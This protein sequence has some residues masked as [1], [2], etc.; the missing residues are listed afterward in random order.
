MTRQV[1]RNLLKTGLI[2]AIAAAAAAPD[3]RGQ[4]PV[5]AQRQPNFIVIY[6]DDLGYADIGPFSTAAK[7]RRPRTPHLDR[8]AAQGARL[9]SF[10]VAQAVCSASRAALLTGSY[11]N[12][13]GITGAL[14]HTT[15][16]GL[17]PDEITI[18]EVLKERGYAT[19][20]RSEEHTSEL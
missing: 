11:S 5:Q 10:Y 13:V 8:M 18:A 16:Y 7:T 1:R 12:R 14:N 6:A 9:T 15:V 4:P 19:A 20:M 17:N 3:E 2:L